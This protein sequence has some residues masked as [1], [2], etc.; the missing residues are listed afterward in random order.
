[1]KVNKSAKQSFE[2]YGTNIVLSASFSEFLSPMPG[3]VPRDPLG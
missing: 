3:L 2:G 1:M